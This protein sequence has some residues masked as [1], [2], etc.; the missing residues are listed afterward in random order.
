MGCLVAIVLFAAGMGIASINGIDHTGS[1]GWDL[2]P[3]LIGGLLIIAAFFS[4]RLFRGD[5]GGRVTDQSQPVMARCR[6]CGDEF[7]SWDDALDHAE[8]V[9][10]HDRLPEEARALLERV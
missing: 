3:D 1:S 7:R 2:M 5:A 9:H 8:D 10:G 4:P 6:A